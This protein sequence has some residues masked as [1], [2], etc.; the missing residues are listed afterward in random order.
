MTGEPSHEQ[1]KDDP[2]T[3][4]Q[5]NFCS[6]N[7]PRAVGGIPLLFPQKKC[8]SMT[9]IGVWA[10]QATVG[11]TEQRSQPEGAAGGDHIGRAVGNKAQWPNRR[12]QV[13]TSNS[14]IMPAPTRES[15]SGPGK[16]GS[17]ESSSY[18]FSGCAKS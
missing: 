9:A 4:Q 12:R 18:S 8:T 5:Q 2:K 14:K 10:A 13:A 11:A 17:G 6:G 15:R 16:S 1:C 3:A 7:N